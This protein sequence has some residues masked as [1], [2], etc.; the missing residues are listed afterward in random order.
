M[1][2]GGDSVP[3]EALSGKKFAMV[4]MTDTLMAT[5]EA[6]GRV[7][8]A[9]ASGARVFIE[10]PAGVEL[11]RKPNCQRGRLAGLESRGDFEA[12]APAVMSVGADGT[13]TGLWL[14]LSLKR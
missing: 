9:V 2:E 12:F 4:L 7:A 14:G 6:M 8:E 13:V 1:S 11:P 10:A 3:S 5:R